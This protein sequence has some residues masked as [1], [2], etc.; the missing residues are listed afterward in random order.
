M[1]RFD[2]IDKHESGSKFFRADIHI[3]SHK[4][5]GSYDV[6]DTN[7]IPSKIIEKAIQENIDIISIT[8]HNSIGNVEE[9]IELSH[10]QPILVIPGV[11]LSTPQGHLL[12]YCPD[13]VSLN[14][15]FNE[16]S[17]SECK[18]MCNDSI[19][20]CLEK[21]K[22][23]GGFGIAAHIDVGAGF[24]M[25]IEKNSPHKKSIVEHPNLLAMEIAKLESFEH[26]SIFD[27]DSNRKSF[28]KSRISDLDYMNCENMAKT[29]SSD[30][31][32]LESIG[33]NINGVS[34][35]TKIKLSELTF[36]AFKIAFLD[37]E[38]RVRIEERLPENI[39]YFYGAKFDGGLLN[40]QCIKF[41]PNLN[42]II[43]GRGA[44]KSTLLESIKVAS[45][46]IST[47]NKIDSE[48]WANEIELFYQDEVGRKQILTRP[49]LDHV[50]NTLNVDGI[51]SVPIEC[52]GQ[53]ETA[54]RIKNCDKNPYILLDF[55]DDL[56]QFDDLFE[57]DEKVIKLL[58]ENNK[59]IHS[60][61]SIILK[62]DEAI[63]NK[64]NIDEKLAILK[65]ES[66]SE[67]INNEIG[68]VSERNFRNELTENLR[69]IVS[70]YR[71]ILSEE[72]LLETV[73]N[74][75]EDAILKGKEEYSLIKNEVE[76][77][78]QMVNDI[79]KQLH[80]KI[81]EMIPVIKTNL[82]KWTAKEVEIQNE[83]TKKRK[84]IEEKGVTV[85]TA[86]IKRISHQ[87]VDNDKLIKEIDEKEK[88][89]VTLIGERN[90]NLQARKLIREEIFNRR[91]GFAS[92]L[93]KSFASNNEDFHVSIK[94]RKG[95]LSNDL[96]IFIKECMG[97][98]SAQVPKANI[99]VSTLGYFGLLEILDNNDIGKITEIR[100]SDG[101]IVFSD[102]VAKNIIDTLSKRTNKGKIESISFD[103]M[104]DINVTNKDATGNHITKKFYQL[105]LGQQQ[106]ILLSVLLNSE[107]KSPLLIDQPEDNL[108]SEFIYRTLVKNL[109]KIKEH[110]QV[111]LVT[112]NANIAVLGDADLILPLKCFNN[113]TEVVYRGSIDR[114]ETKLVSCE[115][116]E[117]SDK[118]FIKR[119]EMYGI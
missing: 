3:H 69:N 19:I 52:Y 76:S 107:S 45:G 39:P 25:Y 32:K 26:Y 108:D 119:K 42:C 84:E 100:T 104:L 35:V 51:T 20:V 29:M 72:T 79:D 54:E 65:K 14:K 118:A 50:I 49:K 28:Y 1:K 98:R 68:L 37:A 58:D 30:A 6:E 8:D 12:I 44:G 41:S 10:G 83:I 18:E 23:H 70:K 95:L 66:A 85:N 22:K 2:N 9:A 46:N 48:I 109:R 92:K 31:H 64:K 97:W 115:Y 47:D 27:T 77:F 61:E 24:D 16:L 89:V 80:D 81:N 106:A 96:S 105:S 102:T 87:K 116:L 17:I 34:K 74:I 71:K 78:N 56:V 4:A 112:H 15:F 67:L 36:K 60:C 55:L 59:A 63:R 103:D 57:R 7:M 73:L 111:I 90:E 93:N 40:N 91:R 11:E 117:G 94:F 38:A 113:N 75:N 88:A 33:K 21:A 62:K 5:K 82:E 86:Y 43:G 114:E 53:G 99:L 110:R 101:D 13:Y